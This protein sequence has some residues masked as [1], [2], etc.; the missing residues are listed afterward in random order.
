MAGRDFRSG[1]PGPGD[2]GARIGAGR[3][4]C[5]GPRGNASD[6]LRLA[7]GEYGRRMVGS[8]SVAAQPALLYGIPLR[9][10]QAHADPRTGSRTGHGIAARPG[11]V[12][13]THS[14]RALLAAASAGDCGLLAWRSEPLSLR[15]GAGGA[16]DHPQRK[17]DEPGDGRW[18]SGLGVA[19][20]LDDPVRLLGA[21]AAGLPAVPARLRAGGTHRVHDGPQRPDQHAHHVDRRGG[22]AADVE[23]AVPRRAPSVSRRSRSTACRTPTAC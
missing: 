1:D 3:A 15:V 13:T 18:V 4:V 10:P 11:C 21:A 6:G 14:R 20:R 16:G 19:V 5:A 9:A 22:T 8:V 12:R 7:P 23:H 17:G 2:T